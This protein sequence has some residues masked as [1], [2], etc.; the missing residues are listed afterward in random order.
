LRFVQALAIGS[1][2]LIESQ[3][4]S[5]AQHRIYFACTYAFAIFAWMLFFFT[6]E[7]VDDKNNKKVSAAP[8]EVNAKQIEE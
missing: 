7:L 2:A 1:F 6:F 3:V 8:S 4:Q 5:V